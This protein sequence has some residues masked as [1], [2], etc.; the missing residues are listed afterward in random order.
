[1]PRPHRAAG[2]DRRALVRGGI[3]FGVHGALAAIGLL[4]PGASLARARAP[5]AFES[6]T[7]DEALAALGVKSPQDARQLQIVG[8]EFPDNGATVDL[9]LKSRLPHTDF[10]ALLVERNPIP[11]VCMFDLPEGT[12]ADLRITIKMKETSDVILLARAQGVHYMARRNL[13]VT[14]GGCG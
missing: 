5:Q 13:K 3:T 1:M 7:L 8:S 9:V 11:L 14:V 4:P 6:T 2:L 10:L 12:E